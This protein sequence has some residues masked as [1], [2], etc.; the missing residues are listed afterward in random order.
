MSV[1]K[2]WQGKRYK[3]KEYKA[4]EKEVYH[5][6]PILKIPKEGPL[7]VYYE[8]GFSSSLSDYDNPIKPLQDILQ[9]KYAFN[10]NR[11]Y[12]ARIKKVKVEKGEE[13]IKF[14]INK[15]HNKLCMSCMKEY[16]EERCEHCYS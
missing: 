11:I 15:M 1:N 14:D 5:L 3:T 8:F 10:D 4:Y 16:E 7:S 6:L 13:Y 9:F 12:E 2:A